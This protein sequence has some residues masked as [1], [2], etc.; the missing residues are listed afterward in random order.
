MIGYVIVG[1]NDIEAAGKFY[2]K[3]LGLLGGN[4]QF[5]DADSISWGGGRY[6]PGVSFMVMKPEDSTVATPGNG[7]IIAL[8]T[9][10]HDEVDRVHSAALLYGGTCEGEPALR[11]EG[12][13]AAYFR[14]PDGN[15]LCAF[16]STW[17]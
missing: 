6:N 13:Y 7:T 11:N 5:E 9:N 1:A 14:D 3:V 10:T 15:K 4:R 17:D 8:P 16:C 2:D 12:W